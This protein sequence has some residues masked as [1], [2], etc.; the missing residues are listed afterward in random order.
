[1]SRILARVLSRIYPDRAA[2]FM[3]RADEIAKNRVLGGVHHPSDIEAG[4]KLGDLVA[5][6]M[7]KSMKLKY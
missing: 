7:L 4:K 1:M 3:Q 6:K 5:N 2:A